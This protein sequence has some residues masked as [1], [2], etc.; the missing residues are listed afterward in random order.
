M[1]TYHATFVAAKRRS[2]AVFAALFP[3]AISA[4]AC[5]T[6]FIRSRSDDLPFVI[7]QNV[8]SPPSKAACWPQSVFSSHQACLWCSC[9]KSAARCSFLVQL[10]RSP[11]TD[12]RHSKTRTWQ[13]DSWSKFHRADE[14]RPG[15]Q[16]QPLTLNP[17]LFGLCRGRVFIQLRVLA[18]NSHE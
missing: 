16:C 17:R 12:R 10:H 15:R 2:L 9:S 7:S 11:I 5:S 14:A 18:A 3:G 13:I 1:A 8:V 6:C 4:G